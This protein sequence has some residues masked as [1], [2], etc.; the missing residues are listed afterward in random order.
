MEWVLN[1]ILPFPKNVIL[2]KAVLKRSRCIT[3]STVTDTDGWTFL[4]PL[5]L[6]EL[7]NGERM[8]STC[9]R[10]LSDGWFL[11]S[12]DGWCFIGCLGGVGSI[13]PP[14][15]FW[16]PSGHSSSIVRLSFAFRFFS[17]SPASSPICKLSV[18]LLISIFGALWLQFWLG[19]GQEPLFLRHCLSSWLQGRIGGGC[20]WDR[21]WLWFLVVFDRFS[22]TGRSVLRDSRDYCSREFGRGRGEFTLLCAAILTA[23]TWSSQLRIFA[24]NGGTVW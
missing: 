8:T 9:V 19:I 1:W 23:A 15:L 22:R 3:V 4:A 16:R 18:D 11:H 21:E 2:E 12:Q 17:S 24:W 13:W 20:R 10:Q 7:L 5:Q 6:D 14:S